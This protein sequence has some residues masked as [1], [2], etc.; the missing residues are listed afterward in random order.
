MTFF[1]GAFFFAAFF[2]AFFFAIT[3][4]GWVWNR[5]PSWPGGT[6]ENGIA[7]RREGRPEHGAARI[8]EARCFP[9]S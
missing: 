2:A 8:V 6:A 4:S 5:R 1:A 7:L 9:R 3:T